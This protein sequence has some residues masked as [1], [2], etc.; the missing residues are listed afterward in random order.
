L[1]AEYEKN[2]TFADFNK[3]K[4]LALEKTQK[5][6]V[7]YN[8][9]YVKIFVVGFPADKL[10]NRD[11]DKPIVVSSLLPHERKISVLNLQVKSS[12][13]VN[14]KETLEI[15]LGF[16]IFSAQPVFSSFINV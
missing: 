1:P 10:A 13:V 3:S 15:H 5:E 11:Q 12:N 7:V 9:F 8:G 4:K 14:S 6:A 16:R 2:F